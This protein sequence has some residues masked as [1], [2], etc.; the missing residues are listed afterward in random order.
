MK[1]LFVFML[2]LSIICIMLK[3]AE[4]RGIKNYKIKNIVTDTDK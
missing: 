3:N 2:I 4:A 1:K